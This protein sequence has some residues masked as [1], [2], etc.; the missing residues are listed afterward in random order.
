M[1]L[2]EVSEPGALTALAGTGGPEF[3]R[4]LNMAGWPKDWSASDPEFGVAAVA[5]ANAAPNP[6]L[7]LDLAAAAD[8][9]TVE[10]ACAAFGAVRGEGTAHSAASVRAV[11]TVHLPRAH[12]PRSPPALAPPGPGGV[13]PQGRPVCGGAVQGGRRRRK[14]CRRPGERRRRAR[15]RPAGQ[16]GRR[17]GDRL[18]PD[19]A[20]K[21]KGS[22]PRAAARVRL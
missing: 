13:S 12:P 2:T 1:Q 19:R 16:A 20:L 18:A 15:A 22:E 14:V 10:A 5:L 4:V 21:V 6:V 9:E 7:V 17:G 11:T 3:F 8:G